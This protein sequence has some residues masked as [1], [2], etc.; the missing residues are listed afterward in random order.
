MAI[1][2]ICELEEATARC[3]TCRGCRS[4][5]HRWGGQKDDR[6]IGHFDK[7]RV[8]VKR[9][10]TFAIVKDETVQYVDFHELAEQNIIQLSKREMQRRAK[11]NVISIRTAE[12]QR[13]S[14]V[15]PDSRSRA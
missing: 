6:I 7:L 14:S 11:A 1:C 12:R 9:M 15:F 13:G 5:I 4:Y 10:T 2:V 3:V 8:R